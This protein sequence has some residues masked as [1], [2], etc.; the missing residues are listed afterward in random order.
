[1]VK[2]IKSIVK[3][4][5][6]H[7]NLRNL[8]IKTVNLENFFMQNEP[9]FKKAE[10]NSSPYMTNRYENFCP[11]GQ[12]KN[13]AKTKPNEPNSNPIRSQI[14]PNQSQF[15]VNL[16]ILKNDKDTAANDD[17]ITD[18]LIAT[19]IFNILNIRT[20][21][22]PGCCLKTIINFGCTFIIFRIH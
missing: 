7:A 13:E 19:G 6:I 16:G 8:R 3:I 11:L 1:M 21:I 2:I 4:Y 10:I 15:S 5:E 14:K 18:A 17:S 20:Y 12:P 22:K 9:N